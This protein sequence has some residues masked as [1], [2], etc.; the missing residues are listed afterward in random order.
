MEVTVEHLTSAVAVIFVH[1]K[2]NTND[3]QFYEKTINLN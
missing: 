1:I 2:A 3:F